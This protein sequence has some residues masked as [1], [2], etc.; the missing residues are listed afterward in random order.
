MAGRWTSTATKDL[1]G[2]YWPSRNS[3][4]LDL[5]GNGLLDTCTV[6]GCPS[7]GSLSGLP[8][9]GDWTGTGTTKLGI[10]DASASPDQQWKLDLNG[11]GNWDGC[12]VDACRGP[13]GVSG[14]LPVAGDWT[15]TGQVRIGVFDPSTGLWDLDLNGNGVFDGC[16]VDAC[17]E[18][19][20]PPQPG[21]LPVVGRW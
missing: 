15:G 6:D 2:I 3:W 18:P 11:N 8:V 12:T 14:D 20:V 19:L 16:T 7:F 21:D 17:L 9:V 10:F 4:R 1:V 5:N 13:F